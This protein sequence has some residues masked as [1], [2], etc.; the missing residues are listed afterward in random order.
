MPGLVHQV[1]QRVPVA[2]GPLAGHREA[3]QPPA[4]GRPEGPQRARVDPVPPQ[5]AASC[6][7][8][9]SLPDVGCARA[10]CR[11]PWRPAPTV[12]SHAGSSNVLRS[13]TGSPLLRRRLP[14][15]PPAA[16]AAPRRE[17]RP[18]ERAR[19]GCG[20]GRVRGGE[21]DSRTGTAHLGLGL[22]AGADGAGEGGG[23]VAPTER[24]AADGAQA[25]LRPSQGCP[26]HR[27]AG[28]LHRLPP[29]ICPAYIELIALADQ[30]R[31]PEG[32]A[33]GAEGMRGS[34]PRPLTRGLGGGSI[35]PSR[36]G[37]GWKAG[38]FAGRIDT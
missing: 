11:R 31:D 30:S 14:G 35:W 16:R 6:S 10:R 9:A 38:A 23:V 29:L 1:A 19:G 26:S 27:Q 18:G 4:G 3:A 34:A 2:E 12:T 8:S 5:P 33:E 17:G 32:R 7:I 28:V 24:P 36:R 20:R 37:G 15:R 21:D 13:S 25:L 22:P